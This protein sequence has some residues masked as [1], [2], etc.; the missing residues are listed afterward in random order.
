[1]SI[2]YKIFGWCPKK[3]PENVSLA[4]DK[5]LN[6]LLDTN[7]EVTDYSG[8][9]VKLGG[10]RIWVSNYPYAYGNPW[11]DHTDIDILPLHKTRLRLREYLAENAWK[12]GCDRATV[13]ELE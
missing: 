3:L 1:M 2:L 11:V 5:R 12:T 4:W 7:P 13:G 10:I 6:E 9:T 8:M